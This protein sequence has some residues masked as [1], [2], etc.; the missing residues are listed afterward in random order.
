MNLGSINSNS[1][2]LALRPGSNPSLTKYPTAS[3]KSLLQAINGPERLQGKHPL[4]SSQSSHEAGGSVPALAKEPFAL[5]DAHLSLSFGAWLSGHTAVAFCFLL[6]FGA[7][8]CFCS[9]VL[10]VRGA[11]ISS[12][13]T[14]VVG[15]PSFPLPLWFHDCL[16]FRK[17]L[18]WIYLWISV[19]GAL[20][21]S[22]VSVLGFEP[23]KRSEVSWIQGGNTQFVKTP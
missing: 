1:V 22:F 18:D 21:P 17:A 12:Q 4:Q 15:L 3:A 20:W 5:F 11:I 6:G 7:E 14:A 16:S 8:P 13:L 19:R 10:S 9:I 2:R 23:V